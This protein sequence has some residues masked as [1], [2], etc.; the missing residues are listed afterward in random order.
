MRGKAEWRASLSAMAAMA[1]VG[2]VSGREMVLFFTQTKAAAWVGML[3]ACLLF[4]VLTAF[5]AGQGEL[6]RG[7]SP[8]ALTC[9]TLRLL[10][11]ALVAAFMLTRL[12]TLGALTLPMHHGFLFGALFGLIAAMILLWTRGGE[13]AGLVVVLALSAF[14]TASALDDR[15][16]R[17]NLRGTAVFA[18]V[19]S[20]PGSLM[21]A[22]AYAALTACAAAWSLRRTCPGTVRAAAVGMRCAA[23]L[24]CALVPGC[25]ALLRAGDMVM[26]QPMPWVVLSARWGLVGFWLC[27]S[28][29]A[30]CSV[31]T[32][33][34]A[35]GLLTSRLRSDRRPLAVYMLVG[36]TAVFCV[37]SFGR[38]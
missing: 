29:Q 21:L 33:S 31:S 26:A 3:T 2:L 28:L 6:C 34:A 24:A 13:M 9:E 27:A 16:A 23:M 38:F 7:R 15:P 36:G 25:A 32:L 37:L 4:G 35:L 10:L 5:I 11:A 1:G 14:Y 8:L 12:G 19:D 17:I 30:V 22:A 18:L 20:V